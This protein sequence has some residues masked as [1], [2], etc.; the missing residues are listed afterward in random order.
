VQVSVNSHRTYSLLSSL[1]KFLWRTL[2]HQNILQVR[3]LL[4]LGST[5]LFGTLVPSI[6]HFPECYTCIFRK[7]QEINFIAIYY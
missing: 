6:D 3:G 7:K 5:G 2:T 4:P 1:S